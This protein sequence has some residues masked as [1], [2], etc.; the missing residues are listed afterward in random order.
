MGLQGHNGMSFL[1]ILDFLVN[2][3]SGLV[4]QVEGI[5]GTLASLQSSLDMRALADQSIHRLESQLEKQRKLFKRSVRDP[6]I[7][8]ALL[9]LLHPSHDVMTPEAL[10]L[11]L[12]ALQIP[13][14]GLNINDTSFRVYE[15]S[16]QVVD[17]TSNEI[18][19]S[20]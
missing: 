17:K 3:F 2:F 9:R 15:D 8:C 5:M 4:S 12:T 10:S 13:H 11:L 16:I 20:E 7:I 18:L 1:L 14:S 6:R 19:A